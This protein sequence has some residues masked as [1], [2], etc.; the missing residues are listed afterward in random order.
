MKG[1]LGFG[2]SLAGFTTLVGKVHKLFM[3]RKK[4]KEKIIKV[5]KVMIK[6]YVNINTPAIFISPHAAMPI[7]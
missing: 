2:A 7:R 4:F 1:L 5:T 3:S 6:S